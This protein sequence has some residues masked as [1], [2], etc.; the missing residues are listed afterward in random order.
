MDPNPPP[1]PG[2]W[3]AEGIADDTDLMVPGRYEIVER[4]VQMTV[5]P[6]PGLGKALR[7]EIVDEEHVQCITL[8][9]RVDRTREGSVV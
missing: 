8:E 6:K 9:V 4:R 1:N 7:I 3:I 5:K 2:H